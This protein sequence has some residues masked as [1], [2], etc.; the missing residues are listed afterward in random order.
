MKPHINWNYPTPKVGWQGEIDK[1]IGPGSTSAELWLQTFFTL[2]FGLFVPLYAWF[3]QLTWTAIQFIFATLLAL[4]MAGGIVTNATSSAKRWYHRPEQTTRDHLLFVAVHILHL[5]LVAWLFRAGDW[6]FAGILTLY[7]LGAT[8]LILKTPLYLQ[9]PMAYGLFALS[10]LFN[11]YF[12]TPISGLEW[13]VPFLF[14]KLLVS[15]LL[16]EEPYRPEREED[17]TDLNS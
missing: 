12:F 9:R 1:F 3:N 7:L 8:L 17:K 15:H 16:R 6:L 5:F 13:F 14:F 11:F 2:S 4:D 10:L